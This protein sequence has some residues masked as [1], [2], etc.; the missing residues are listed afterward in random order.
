M[1]TDDRG[2]VVL[3]RHHSSGFVSR[4]TLAS[5]FSKRRAYERP[6]IDLMATAPAVPPHPR[7][8]G[9]GP[10]GVLSGWLGMVGVGVEAGGTTGPQVDALRESV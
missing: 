4:L 2:D 6:A 1:N 5:M 9:M 7:P 10:P 3:A 8:V